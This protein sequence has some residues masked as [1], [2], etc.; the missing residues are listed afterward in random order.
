MIIAKSITFYV[1]LFTIKTTKA[2]YCV[3]KISQP[4]RYAISFLLITIYFYRDQI[5]TLAVSLPGVLICMRNKGFTRNSFF[6]PYLY[7]GLVSWY[8]F[9]THSEAL[10]L[11]VLFVYY[12]GKMERCNF[13]YLV[14]YFI[15]L[16]CSFM[17]FPLYCLYER[18][19][20][21]Y[22]SRKGKYNA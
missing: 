16:F 21:W 10:C 7:P 18:V 9:C 19:F 22:F 14:I 6:W 5:L 4:H 3:Y 17:V 1:N 13:I 2:H 12:T 20:R 8:R 11:F 15:V